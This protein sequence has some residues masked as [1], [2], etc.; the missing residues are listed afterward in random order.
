MSTLWHTAGGPPVRLRY[1]LRFILSI[2]LAVLQ[3]RP[4]WPTSSSPLLHNSS[5]ASEHLNCFTQTLPTWKNAVRESVKETASVHRHKTEMNRSSVYRIT[6]ARHLLAKAAAVTAT[7]RF[8]T[9]YFL[10][11][12][13]RFRV[14]VLWIQFILLHSVLEISLRAMPELK[15]SGNS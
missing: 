8:P 9:H 6:N 11:H 3:L 15:N 4:V 2:L 10:H 7:G 14:V 1:A 5:T 12:S 13:L